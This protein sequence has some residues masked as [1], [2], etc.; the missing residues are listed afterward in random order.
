MLTSS[1]TLPSLNLP[2]QLSPA[3]GS[4]RARVLHV[5]KFYPPEHGGMESHVHELVSELRDCVEQS[6]VVA[7]METK[8]RVKVRILPQNTVQTLKRSVIT[9]A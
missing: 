8:Q 3:R 5:G 9:D 1:R 4:A 6:V 2:L 7:R